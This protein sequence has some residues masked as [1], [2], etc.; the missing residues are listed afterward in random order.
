MRINKRADEDQA[1]LERDATAD[2]LE[3]PSEQA[4]DIKGGYLKIKL[5]DETS[6]S[7]SAKK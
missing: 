3:V 2:D 6:A 1:R 7:D 4:G 5:T